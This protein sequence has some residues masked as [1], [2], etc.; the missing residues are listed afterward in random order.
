M[1]GE[2]QPCALCSA[3]P[4]LHQRRYGS[5]AKCHDGVWWRLTCDSDRCPGHHGRWLV[6]ASKAIRVW[7]GSQRSKSGVIR[8]HAE[9][10]RL[11]LQQFQPV[12]TENDR[13]GGVHRQYSSGDQ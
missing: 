2:I 10:Q 1:G 5:I 11:R 4:T 13:S 9:A 3:K 6:F 12:P 7:N 8:R